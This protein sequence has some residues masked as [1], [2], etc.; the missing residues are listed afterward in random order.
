MTRQNPKDLTVLKYKLD[1]LWPKS[2][3]VIEIFQARPW[4]WGSAALGCGCQQSCQESL[5][6]WATEVKNASHKTGDQS[7]D[8]NQ[9]PTN[10]KGDFL[11]CKEAQ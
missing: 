10:G 3:Q 2:K 6:L 8:Q 11:D 5:P 1:I 9:E 4:G 7:Q